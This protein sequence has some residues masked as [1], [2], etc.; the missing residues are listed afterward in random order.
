[1]RAFDP[2]DNAHVALL[3][4]W[5]WTF[6]ETERAL[7]FHTRLHP[8]GA[9]L[10]HFL[11]RSADLMF[12][13]DGKGI[14]VA[15]WTVPLADAAEFSCWVRADRRCAP[16]SWRELQL[17]Y[18]AALSVYPALVG[19]TRQAALHAAHLKMGYVYGGRLNHIVKEGPVYLYELTREAYQQRHITAKRVRDRKREQR[20]PPASV[21]NGNGAIVLEDEHV[22]LERQPWA[23][24]VLSRLRN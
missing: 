8:L 4:Q 14:Y 5:F 9:F 10:Q 3:F 24:R 7:L 2:A 23:Q 12:E 22:E 18:Q 21:P 19:V 13:V 15:V 1:M 17:G 16:S 20:Q 11:S 6:T